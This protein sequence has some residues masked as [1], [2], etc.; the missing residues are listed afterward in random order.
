M[1]VLLASVVARGV[2]LVAAVIPARSAARM[3]PMQA[4]RR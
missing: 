1:L 4:I 3:D 2:G